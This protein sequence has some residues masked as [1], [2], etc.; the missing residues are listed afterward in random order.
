MVTNVRIW[1]ALKSELH[2]NII[3]KVLQPDQNIGENC[4]TCVS[5]SNSHASFIKEDAII[6]S[7][8]LNE[9]Q[10]DS[11]L[12]SVDMTKCYHSN[13]KLIW[14]PPGTGKTKTVACLLYTLHKLKTRTLTCA[15][16]NTAILQVAVRLHSLVM[17]SLEHDTYGLGDIVLFGNSKRMKIDCYMGLENIFLDNRVK[18]FKKFLNPETGWKKSLELMKKL[19]RDPQDQY[20]FEIC[21]YRAYR[22]YKQ[23]I[24]NE[25]W[26]E[27]AGL[28]L[29]VEHD[30]KKNIMSMEQFEDQI[31]I[32]MSIKKIRFMELREQL[33]LCTQTLFE[34]FTELLK[35]HRDQHFSEKGDHPTTFEGFVQKA[36]KEIV[37]T[38]ELDEDD[39]NACVLTME[40]FV[41]QRFGN[42]RDVLEFLNH[43]LYTH[44]PKSF[45]SLETVKVMLQAPSLFESFE[46]S[47]SQAKFK[48][49]LYNIEE[50]YVSDCFGPLCDK[51]DEILSILSLLSSSI[52]LPNIRLER[53]AIEIFCLSNTCLV[54]CTASSSG[55]LYTK[56]MI[57]VEFVVIDEAAQL[58]ECETTIPLQL[59]GLS[60]CILIGDERQ[61]P[62]LVKSKIADKCE[63]G[64]SMFERLVMLGYKRK[65]LNVQ[66]RMHPSISLFPCKEFYE[67][68]L[69]DASIV[70]EESYNK[71]FLEGE[72]YASYSFI[73][74][75]EGKEKFGRGYSLKNMVEVAVISE[76]IQSLNREFMRT[77]KKVS[78]GIISPYNAQVYEIQEKVKQYTRVSNSDFSVS[79]RS[80]DGFQ[81]GEEDII[82]IS[83][84][85]S[86]GSGKVGFLSN[87]QR[88]NVAMTRARYCLWILGNA[89][90]LI[91]SDS[92][93]RNVVLDAK[94]RDCFH[95]ANENKKLAV[96][97]EGVLFEL[98]LLEESESPFKK[99]LTLGGK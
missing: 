50:Q 70:M 77:K 49:T 61:L 67:E 11:I 26:K 69:S 16:T 5:E 38:Y 40:Q 53:C 79:V 57:P 68:K 10:E 54:L 8:K 51:R 91:N 14:G 9:S 62:A 27:I 87:R 15:P 32:E 75:A 21:A 95:N 39:E 56:E 74:I 93:W 85:R 22:A 36:W 20:L 44:L 88:T 12:S 60:H 97:I 24:G 82:I 2:G 92:V 58:K 31:F 90:T 81:G 6:C 96:A 41:K 7:Q 23:N 84:V 47:L 72:M 71:S 52:S 25:A 76:I 73:N 37:H 64:R 42:L 18:I 43:A 59:P 45:V 48:Q 83:T 1:K 55:K 33:K 46:N 19:L 3:P 94:K 29:M 63:F 80:V 78:I 4:Q 35:G 17:Q 66:Y 13:V 86:N 30:I 89:A 65:M 98:E 99:K 34:R 28:N